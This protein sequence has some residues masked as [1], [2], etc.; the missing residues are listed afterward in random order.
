[1]NVPSTNLQ[2]MRRNCPV[3]VSSKA[4]AVARHGSSASAE[5]VTESRPVTATSSHCVPGI[6]SSVHADTAAVPVVSVSSTV[7]APTCPLALRGVKRTDAP[8]TGLS[9]LSLTRTVG[10]IV[11][12]A[13]AGTVCESPA[14]FSS[15]AGAPATP[16]T[17]NVAGASPE[18]VAVSVLTPVLV[19]SVHPPAVAT[20]SAPV[21][22][23]PPVT[24]PPPAVTAN[25]TATWA[26]GC[27]F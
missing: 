23:A 13:P 12:A 1:M 2:L 18:T 14:T 19:P 20:P 8:A 15:A 17:V 5:N 3:T 4:Y 27:P 16:V 25:V 11:T 22:T 21:V 7:S 9:Y 26:T 6:V 10:A 24:E